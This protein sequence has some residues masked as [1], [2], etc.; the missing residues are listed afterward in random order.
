VTRVDVGEVNGRSFINNSSIGLYPEL[1]RARDEA[2]GSHRHG[3]WRAALAALL[4]FVRV[5]TAQRA[6]ASKTPVVFVGNNAYELGPRSIGQ[7]ARLDTGKLSLYLVRTTSRLRMIWIALRAIFQR[8]E[9]VRDLEAISVTE[10]LIDPRRRRVD[11]AIDGEV[12]RLAA[13]LRYRILPG[14]LPVIA[15]V[16]EA[17]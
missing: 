6:V 1:V 14:A 8:V 5:R 2:G 12:A 11:V 10:A 3:I 13:P 4:H 7:R 9:A 16:P 15:P 17:A